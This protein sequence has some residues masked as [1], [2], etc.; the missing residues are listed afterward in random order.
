MQLLLQYA[1]DSSACM[2]TPVKEIYSKSTIYHFQLIVKV[3]LT[4][5][6]AVCEIFSRNG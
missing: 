3:L 6:L 4:V 5:L 2:E 1:R